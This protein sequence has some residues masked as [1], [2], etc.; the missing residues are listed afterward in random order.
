MAENCILLCV[1]LVGH[2]AS[3]LPSEALSSP[4]VAGRK[5]VEEAYATLWMGRMFLVHRL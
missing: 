2:A 1:Y 3:R 4:D 5:L